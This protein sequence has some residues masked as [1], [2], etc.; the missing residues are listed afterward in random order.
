MGHD[1]SDMT[2]LLSGV[3]ML[4][5]LAVIRASGEEAAHFLQGQ[6]TQDFSLLDLSDARLCAY[7]TAKGRMLASF[8]GLKRS[9]TGVC[10]VTPEN[11]DTPEMKE[12]LNPPLEK[13]LK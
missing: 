6:L 10:V 12:L 11:L 1:N 8:V 13:Y 9:D 7:C 4:P 2:Q 5:N 3:A